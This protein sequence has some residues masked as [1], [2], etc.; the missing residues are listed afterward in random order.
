MSDVRYDVIVV[1][2]GISGLTAAWELQNHG[3]RVLVLEADSRVGGRIWTRSVNGIVFEQGAQFFQ[4]HFIDLRRLSTKLAVKWL[5]LPFLMGMR[6][7]GRWQMGYYDRL[8]AIWK[9]PALGL[10][11]APTLVKWLIRYKGFRFVR[12]P[13]HDSLRELFDSSPATL[14]RYLFEPYYQS[15]FFSS[16]SAG[17]ISHLFEHFSHP[18]SQRLFRPS[19]GMGELI[20]ALAAPL[21]IR[22]HQCV[23]SIRES[24][25]GVQISISHEVFH[26]DYAI[27]AAP[28]PVVRKIID[29]AKWPTPW[30]RVIETTTYASTITALVELEGTLHEGVFGYSIPPVERSSVASITVYRNRYLLVM[31]TSASAQ[32]R[33]AQ[34]DGEIRNFFR[35]EVAALF[36]CSSRDVNVILTHK[37]PAAIPMFPPGRFLELRQFWDTPTNSRIVPVGDYLDNG[38]TEGA[39]RSSQK[40][41]QIVMDKMAYRR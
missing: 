41:V 21:T 11:Y 29:I 2:A 40:A 38:C 6:V 9:A 13:D 20:Q 12:H 1:G 7:G 8:S 33:M 23:E 17:S 34:S 30:Q 24:E 28:A 3:A 36:D 19:Q 25:E 16:P 4:Q 22:L 31:L 26:A 5:R 15:M 27:V 32:E 10:S 37:W 18:W 14:A 35:S 39:V